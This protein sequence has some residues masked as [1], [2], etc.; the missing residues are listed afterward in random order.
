MLK[1][2]TS[3]NPVPSKSGLRRLIPILALSL[4]GL[5]AAIWLM[6]R[7]QGEE[8]Y[9]VT[10]R[11]EGAAAESIPVYRGNVIDATGRERVELAEGHLYRVRIFDESREGTAGLARIGGMIVFVP[12]TRKGEVV[13]VEVLAKKRT[14][15]DGRLVSRE[16]AAPAVTAPKP[17]ETVL[18]AAAPGLQPEEG[19]LYR[20]RLTGQ[21]R[22]GD[23]TLRLAGRTVYVKGGK[24]GET[25]TFRVTRISDRYI[26]AERVDA[27][28]APAP[29]AAEPAP[30]PTTVLSGADSRADAVQ[31]GA[32]FDVAITEPSRRNPDHDG[33][34]RIGGLIVIVPDCRPGQTV[35][36]RIRERAERY[37]LAE[38]VETEGRP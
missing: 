28:A 1:T 30:A 37:A 3:A 13:V 26:Q 36:I 6:L 23:G 10:R 12:D 25:V 35:R 24:E 4:V 15:A 18:D 16:S 5:V 31:P 32:V 8:R 33:V 9:V 34:A 11:L 38:R 7:P 22:E 27:P 2:N 14:T 19:R 21:G 17:T 20:G 29:A